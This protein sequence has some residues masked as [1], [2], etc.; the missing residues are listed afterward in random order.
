MSR[1]IPCAVVAATA[2][3]FVTA[4]ARAQVTPQEAQR[5]ERIAQATAARNAGDHARALEFATQAGQ[6][7]MSVSLRLMI[8]EEHAALGGE[9]HTGEAF[10]MAEACVREATADANVPQREQV[11]RDC[12][13]LMERTRPRPVSTPAAPVVSA[14]VTPPATVTVVPP[15][16][17]EGATR[18]T[19]PARGPGVGP[20]LVV[21][22]GGALVAL[23][24]VFFAL[25]AQA[26]L[27]RALECPRVGSNDVCPN[28]AALA[29]ATRYH[30]QAVQWNAAAWVSMGVGAAAVAGGLVWYALARKGDEAP[31]TALRWSVTPVREGALT[32]VEGV[33]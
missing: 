28:S 21:G 29:N 15:R 9:V 3:M 22:G 19:T 13:N 16:V 6:I 31:R 33:W 11:L 10:R 4:T 30:E 24:G 25:Q 27:S 8:A 1:V 14:P 26:Q 32:T 23:G 18:V 12:T 17:G 7:R 20:W 2:L 5:R